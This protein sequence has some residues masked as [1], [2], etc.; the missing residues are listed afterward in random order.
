MDET[1]QNTTNVD[2]DEQT[3]STDNE[4]KAVINEQ[5]SKIQRQGMLLGAQAICSVI[6]E[7]ISAAFKGP[8]KMSMNDYRRLVKDIQQFCTTGLSR[9]VT[10]DGETVPNNS[11]EIKENNTKLMED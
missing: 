1:I 4:L 6:L 7:K 5:M 3:T 2:L 10:T 9:K 11:A 8:G